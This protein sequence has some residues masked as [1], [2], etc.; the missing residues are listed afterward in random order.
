MMFGFDACFAAAIHTGY[1]AKAGSEAN[2]LAHTTNLRISRLLL[3]GEVASEFTMN[4]LCA[5]RYGVPS[6]SLSGD[7]EI[8]VDAQRT[9]PGVAT[10]A[11]RIG[12]G[13]AT[14]SIA[15][16]RARQQ[17]REGVESALTS[18]R[19]AAP[20]LASSYEMVIEMN[21]PTG[22]YRASGYPGARNHGPRTVAFEHADFGEILRTFMFMKM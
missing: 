16:A 13:S 10:V 7:A 22:V 1:H 14:N 20:T 4:A 6:V 18:G 5:A 15:P 19:G 21:N 2:P 11:T 9:V 12:H 17:I 8:C 3:N